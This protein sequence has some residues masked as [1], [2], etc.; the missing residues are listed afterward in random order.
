MASVSLAA[1]ALVLLAEPAP[2]VASDAP[3]RT[4]GTFTVAPGVWQLELGL[5]VATP[6]GG[7]PA[8]V[9]PLRVPTTL[10]V[11]VSPRVELRAFDGDRL[12][13]HDLR[14]GVG[15]ETS[16]GFKI[17]FNDPQ[18]RF[19]R[20]PTFGV[21]PYLAFPMYG[22][23][24]HP[25]AIALGAALLWAQPLTRW[26]AVDVNGGFELALERGAPPLTGFV[27][28]STQ[29]TIRERWLPYL[30]VY[31]DIRGSDSAAIEVGADAGFVFVA[32]RRVAFN[33]AGRATFVAPVLSHGVLA[34]L[35]VLLADGAR[36][37]R[38]IARG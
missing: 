6:F 19:G 28:A 36:C 31:G 20:R 24:K 3:D 25:D 26:L 4:N 33:V 21:Q 13:H 5:D 35:A 15:G 30:E 27:S 14:R 16:F 22:L 10:R 29:A 32:H 38:R 2:T 11:G 37:R 18:V 8:G 23:G 9:V 34:G 12:L 7:L 1:V 17:R